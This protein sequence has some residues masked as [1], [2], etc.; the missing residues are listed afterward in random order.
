MTSMGCSMYGG[1]QSARYKLHPYVTGTAQGLIRM[2]GILG[3]RTGR[4]SY[5][6]WL[7]DAGWQAGR[8]R[9]ARSIREA[10]ACAQGWLRTC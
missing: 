10:D 2:I 3:M 4:R 8:K 6:I 7:V 1:V 5:C 9:M